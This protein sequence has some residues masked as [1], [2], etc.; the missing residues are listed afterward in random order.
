MKELNVRVSSEWMK[1]NLPTLYDGLLILAETFANDEFDSFS[2]EDLEEMKTEGFYADID[3]S[4]F[5]EGRWQVITYVNGS[6]EPWSTDELET[7]EKE[8]IEA[9]MSLEDGDVIE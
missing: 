2:F 4:E 6:T 3:V 7:F 9:L 5:T 1:E 8:E